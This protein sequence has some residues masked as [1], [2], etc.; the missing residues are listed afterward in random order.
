MLNGVG[1][2]SKLED[3]A[4]RRGIIIVAAGQMDANSRLPGPVMSICRL[5]SGVDEVM[6]DVI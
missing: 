3:N 2:L 4:S 1:E 6:I 5:P